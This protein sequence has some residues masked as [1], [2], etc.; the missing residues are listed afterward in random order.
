MALELAPKGKSMIASL[1]MGLAW[2]MG[3]MIIPLVGK[4]ADFFSIRAVLFF[5]AMI[6][7][8]SNSLISLLPAKKLKQP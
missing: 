8:L 4:L 6:P 7:L 3:G 5:V 1:M 2:G